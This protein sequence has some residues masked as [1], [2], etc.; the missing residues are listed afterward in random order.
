MADPAAM[1]A[2]NWASLTSL[3]ASASTTTMLAP[4]AMT[5]AHWMSSDSSSSAEPVGSPPGVLVAVIGAPCPSTCSK[6]G[7]L[8]RP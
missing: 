4:G 6:L 3:L 1:V 7:G 2:A 5:W 8:G